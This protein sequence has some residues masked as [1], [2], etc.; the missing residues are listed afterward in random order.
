[1]SSNEQSAYARDFPQTIAYSDTAAQTHPTTTSAAA[2]TTMTATAAAVDSS[3][4][5]STVTDTTLSTEIDSGSGTPNQAPVSARG[6]SSTAFIQGLDELIYSATAVSGNLSS[7]TPSPLRQEGPE[8]VAV[9]GRAMTPASDRYEPASASPPSRMNHLQGPA[10]P[11]SPPQ[12][13]HPRVI[14]LS[15]A[16][17]T[18]ATADPGAARRFEQF[19]LREG[20]KKIKE[21]VDTRVSHAS[22]F[23]FAGE[24]HTLGNLLRSELLRSPHV[25][26]AAYKVPHPLFSSFEL[27]VQTDGTVTP[28][29]AV[30]IASKAAV[31]NF[32]ILSREFTKEMELRK[33]VGGGG[34]GPDGAG[35]AGGAG[36]NAG[37]GPGQTMT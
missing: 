7:S 6:T 31:Q 17:T 12:A 29:E 19:L 23:T 27:R 11:S 5:G 16:G 10:T 26:F 1:M 18:R 24:D 2:A 3:E 13:Q 15:G 21:V 22:T 8:P 14:Q 25:T 35:G 32:A 28:S 30:V 36:A 33:M 37:G 9:P 4:D 34:N 20:E